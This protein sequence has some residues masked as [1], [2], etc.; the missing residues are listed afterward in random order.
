MTLEILNFHT[1]SH[2]RKSV[3]RYICISIPALIFSKTPTTSSTST[4]TCTKSTPLCSHG[5]LCGTPHP[6]STRRAGTSHVFAACRIQVLPPP[7]RP[8]AWTRH[9]LSRSTSRA[10]GIDPLT[11][12]SPP[13]VPTSRSRCHCG[14]HR[15]GGSTLSAT[16]ICA[17]YTWR[18]AAATAPTADP[19]TAKTNGSLPCGASVSR[20]TRRPPLF[21][22]PLG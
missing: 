3:L 8:P 18:S 13:A 16:V 21:T 9:A 17:E 4:R 10:S 7:H 1:T 6:A 15:T 19:T 12:F 14:Q 20:P 5:K 11:P 22:R 2:C